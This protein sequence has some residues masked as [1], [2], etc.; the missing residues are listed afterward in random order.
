M[1]FTAVFIG[2]DSAPRLKITWSINVKHELLIF[3]F[4]FMKAP[5]F[6]LLVTVDDFFIYLL[7][8]LSIHS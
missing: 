4:V 5:I 7:T 6:S 8:Y 1:G 3:R 2:A